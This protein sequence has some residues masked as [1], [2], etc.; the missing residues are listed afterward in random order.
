M[1][2]RNQMHTTHPEQRKYVD[3]SRQEKK[4]DDSSGN[5]T[6]VNRIVERFARTGEMPPMN[7]SNASYMDAS[8]FGDLAEVITKGQE[9]QAT[10]DKLQAQQTAKAAQQAAEN[11]KELERL[12]E[13][14]SAS[15]ESDNKTLDGS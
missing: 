4:V 12:R 2:I 7:Q 3:L 1:K 11:A 9:A 6:D 8:Q 15:S 10:L 5:D 13:R 14:E